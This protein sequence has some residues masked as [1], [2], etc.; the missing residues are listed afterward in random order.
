SCPERRA[1]KAWGVR[2]AALDGL[3]LLEGLALLVEVVSEVG[4]ELLEEVVYGLLGVLRPVAAGDLGAR[5]A[6]LRV[7][8]FGQL[9]QELGHAI[10][11]DAVQEAVR[12]GV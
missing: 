3:G 1:V 8:A 4:G 11:V 10:D 12:G 6:E 2:G 5:I 9:G 7:G